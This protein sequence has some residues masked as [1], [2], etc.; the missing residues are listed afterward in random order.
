MRELIKRGK[1]PNRPIINKKGG[2]KNDEIALVGGS[3]DKDGG[4][5]K[6]R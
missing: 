6:S 4:K 2:A 5:V 3:V 1:K